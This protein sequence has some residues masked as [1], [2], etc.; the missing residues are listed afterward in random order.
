MMAWSIALTKL[1]SIS[2]YEKR[3]CIKYIKQQ[4]NV[5]HYSDYIELDSLVETPR[6]TQ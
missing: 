1:S 2:H 6:L 5:D 3:C 4:H